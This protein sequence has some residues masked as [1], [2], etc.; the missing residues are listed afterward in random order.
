MLNLVKFK[1]QKGS[2]PPLNNRYSFKPKVFGCCSA[3]LTLVEALVSLVILSFGLIPALAILSSSTRISSLIKNNLIAANLAQ[4]GVEVVRSLRD[5]NWF[6]NRPFDN[7]L[8]GQ[9]RVEW[10]TNWITKPPVAVGT[11]PP[12]KFNLATGTYNYLTGEDTN[13]RRWISV[14]VTANPCNCELVVVSRVDWI[15]QGKAKTINVESHL[16]DWK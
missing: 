2:A 7:G 5:A 1:N 15:Q 16:Y 14:V 11:N 9:W 10:D 4:E 13:F 6:A 8:V 3:G 12:L